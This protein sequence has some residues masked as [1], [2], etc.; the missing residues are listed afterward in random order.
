[1]IEIW[2]EAANFNTRNQ[3]LADHTK[4]I[5]KKGWFSGFKIK[6]IYGQVSHEENNHKLPKSDETQNMENQTLTE[7]N[8]IT[9][10]WSQNKKK[11]NEINLKDHD[12][13]ERDIS[14]PKESRLEK[15]QD[16]N[17]KGK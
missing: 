12:W 4:M 9:P 15:S 10:T 7:T 2:K 11:N 8:I 1:M 3:R 14:I 17:Q 6:E 5:L 13:K 16:S